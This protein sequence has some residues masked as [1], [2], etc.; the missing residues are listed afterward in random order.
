MEPDLK[1]AAET[2]LRLLEER[3]VSLGRVRDWADEQIA[4]VARPPTWL[5]AVS[6]A[7]TSVAA[8][9]ALGEVPGIA[10]ATLVWAA[11]TQGWLELLQKDPE[12]DSDIAKRLYFMGMAGSSPIEGIDGELLSFWDDIDLARDGIYGSRETEREKLREFLARWTL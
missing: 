12:R 11:L 4:N 9:S 3:L 10:N 2:Q 1:T 6:M 7:D 8:I 5:I